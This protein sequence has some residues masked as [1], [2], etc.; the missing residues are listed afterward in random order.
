MLSPLSR[1][2]HLKE[3]FRSA[4]FVPAHSEF[5]RDQISGPVPPPVGSRDRA[6]NLVPLQP[7]KNVCVISQALNGGDAHEKGISDFGDG[8]HRRRNR[9][10]RAG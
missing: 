9:D 10:D 7:S 5:L 1:L 8:C 4:G 3:E 2:L 6:K